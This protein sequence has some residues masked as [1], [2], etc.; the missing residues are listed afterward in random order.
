MKKFYVSIVAIFM[1]ILVTGCGKSNPIVGTWEGATEDGLA[2]TWEFKSNNKVDY[3]DTFETG[4]G[5]YEIDGNT[6][7]ISLDIKENEKVYEFKVEGNTL[8]MLATDQVS[9]SYNKLTKK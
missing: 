9:P 4:T 8:T 2:T 6:I 3:K 1:L 7:K 5:K